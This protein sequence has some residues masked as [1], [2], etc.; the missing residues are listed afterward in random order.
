MCNLYRKTI[1]LLNLLAI[2]SLTESLSKM[3]HTLNLTLAFTLGQ[4]VARITSVCYEEERRDVLA[5]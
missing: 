2:I 1:L 3:E 4:Q 5:V